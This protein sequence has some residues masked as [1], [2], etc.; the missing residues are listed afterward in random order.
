MR[1]RDAEACSCRVAGCRR[2]Q[3]RS[4]LDRSRTVPK[5]RG[6][7]Q[8]RAVHRPDGISVPAGHRAGHA[9][10]GRDHDRSPSAGREL[11]AVD[12]RQ[13]LGA[14]ASSGPVRGC[15]RRANDR[16]R[17][18]RQRPPRLDLGRWRRTRTVRRRRTA[19]ARFDGLLCPLRRRGAG[20]RSAVDAAR[21]SKR[22]SR[23][24]ASVTEASVAMSG[25]RASS[26]SWSWAAVWPAAPPP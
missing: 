1:W 20:R 10:R 8:R 5:P 4:R 16:P 6:L 11:P 9:G 22:P 19:A 14:G 3:R 12:P 13:G 25:T 24:S 17:V 18:W 21:R 2:C 23:R 7:D 26:T 15:R